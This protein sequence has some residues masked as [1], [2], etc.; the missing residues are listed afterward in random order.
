MDLSAAFAAQFKKV[1]QEEKAAREKPLREAK[2]KVEQEKR[3]QARRD[4]G[5]EVRSA[6]V[7]RRPSLCLRLHLTPVLGWQ[8][9]DIAWFE[10]DNNVLTIA[11][12][13]LFVLFLG[14]TQIP[15]N[16]AAEARKGAL[17]R[18]NYAYVRCLD[19]AYGLSEKVVCM[20]KYQ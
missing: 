20:S 4:L 13:V 9:D 8:E 14:A 17:E 2:A 18:E 15:G 7:G 10:R 19:T 6:A 5:F 12:S 11:L 16:A 3:A 1:E